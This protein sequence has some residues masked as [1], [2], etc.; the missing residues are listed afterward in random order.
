MSQAMSISCLQG[1]ENEAYGFHPEP[2]VFLAPYEVKPI[3][4]Q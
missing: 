1:S 3:S 2:T 4:L